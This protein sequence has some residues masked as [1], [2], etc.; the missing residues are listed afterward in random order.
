MA[1][2][3]LI[4]IDKGT[5][6]HQHHV[7]HKTSS[8]AKPKKSSN[9]HNTHHS[10]HSQH[11]PHPQHAKTASSKP[12]SK[13]SRPKQSKSVAKHQSTPQPARAKSI[14]TPQTTHQRT[15]THN[16][17]RM[18]ERHGALTLLKT[19]HL[20]LSP[21]GYEPT[22]ATEQGKQ[23]NN[24]DL[25]NK[26]YPD[27]S[28]QILATQTNT[29]EQVPQQTTDPHINQIPQVSNLLQQSTKPIGRKADGSMSCVNNCLPADT[30]GI[31]SCKYETGSS[32][33]GPDRINSKEDA[34]KDKKGGRSYG[35][36]Q[37]PEKAGTLKAYLK[38]S[39]YGYLFKGLTPNTDAFDKQWREVAWAHPQEFAQDQMKFIGK[40]HYQPFLKGLKHIG[41][42]L[43]HRG[44]AV[45]EM[46]WSI[47]VQ[48]GQ[49]RGTDLMQK[50]LKKQ[51]VTK[52]SDRQ[53][54]EQV[55][56]YKGKPEVIRYY[57]RS[58]PGMRPGIRRRVRKEKKEVL[59]LLERE[60]K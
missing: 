54:I 40:T 29:T 46:I 13:H 17:N 4:K 60:N 24:I 21:G 49:G 59:N 56:D 38:A 30:L 23:F 58:S 7:A 11:A 8:K 9:T 39:K 47:A 55:Y 52:M 53:L 3:Q 37:Y 15:T 43:T 14:A 26:Y 48:Y 36:P 16:K 57:F 34:K 12:G 2:P 22:I 41:I 45:Q 5:K 50:A 35:L 6:S 44:R 19:D 28:G 10:N 42:D 20:L 33:Y 1:K 25:L 18:S 32:T 31:I 51:N 27:E